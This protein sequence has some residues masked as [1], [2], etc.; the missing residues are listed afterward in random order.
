MKQ[1]NDSNPSKMIGAGRGNALF[2]YALA[3]QSYRA[4]TKNYATVA[5]P[6]LKWELEAHEAELAAAQR[7]QDTCWK[8]GEKYHPRFRVI[9]DK[10]RHYICNQCNVCYCMSPESN[11]RRNRREPPIPQSDAWMGF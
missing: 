8:C 1:I 11:R 10:C 2:D 4:F 6:T 3:L 9:R 5:C 7:A